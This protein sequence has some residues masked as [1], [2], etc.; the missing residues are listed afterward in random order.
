MSNES[1]DDTL[2]RMRASYGTFVDNITMVE[3]NPKN[4]PK[5]LLAYLPYAALWGIADDVEREQRV[6]HAPAQAKQ[7]LVRTV[8]LIEEQLE[9][10]LA[11]DEADSATPSKEYI[12]FSAMIMA[13]DFV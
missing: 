13:A 3:L 10:W 12:A 2:Q 1:I 6:M 9:T 4:V 11:G 7:D 8:R 5:G